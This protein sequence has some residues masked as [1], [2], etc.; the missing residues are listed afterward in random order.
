[1]SHLPHRD[2][3]KYVTTKSMAPK[4]Y[5]LPLDRDEDRMDISQILVNSGY[6]PILT[7]GVG[8]RIKKGDYVVSATY[9]PLCCGTVMMIFTIKR[10]VNA[11]DGKT[12]Y[13]HRGRT[14]PHNDPLYPKNIRL[15]IEE[16]DSEEEEE[17][18]PVSEMITVRGEKEVIPMADVVS[19]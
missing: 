11:R 7:D 9:E 2:D 6:H 12:V 3:D 19:E 13:V 14:Y 15:P 4:I 1:M 16:E 17:G 18:A 8:T 5:I 10:M